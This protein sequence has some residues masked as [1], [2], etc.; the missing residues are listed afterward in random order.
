MN[1]I[2]KAIR[3]WLGVGEGRDGMPGPQG[4][5]GSAGVGVK[6]IYRSLSTGEWQWEDTDGELH[7]V[8]VFPKE[9][10]K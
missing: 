10:R 3:G 6:A 5:A 4:A 8:Q 7:V 1:R 2:K 9:I